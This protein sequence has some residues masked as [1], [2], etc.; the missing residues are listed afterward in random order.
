MTKTNLYKFIETNHNDFDLTIDLKAAGS[1]MFKPIDFVTA[2]AVANKIAENVVTEYGDYRPEY[3]KPLLM[4]YLL[5]QSAGIKLGE[6][7]SE[8]MFLIYNSEIGITLDDQYDDKHPWLRNLANL[9]DDKIQFRKKMYCDPNSLVN[10]KISELIMKQLENEEKTEALMGTLTEFSKSFNSEEI[11]EFTKLASEL[12]DAIQTPELS[13]DFFKRI[14]DNAQ[15]KRVK[16]ADAILEKAKKIIQM[17][18][19]KNVLVNKK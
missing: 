15:D 3:K 13:D 18:K 8:K 17:D 7:D 11:R 16:E 5:E 19:A 6:F 10:N 4:H 12:N 14:Q 9:I 2:V 1:L